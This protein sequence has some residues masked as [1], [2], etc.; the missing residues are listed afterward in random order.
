MITAFLL[1]FCFNTKYNTINTLK[2][3]TLKSFI[4]KY[5]QLLHIL[6]KFVITVL[7]HFTMLLNNIQNSTKSKTLLTYTFVFNV[8][9]KCT[10]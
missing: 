9:T 2:H 10:V 8:Y 4:E 6:F 3:I 5:N 1:L 7:L